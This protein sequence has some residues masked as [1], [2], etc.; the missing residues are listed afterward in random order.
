MAQENNKSKDNNKFTYPVRPI[1]TQPQLPSTPALPACLVS[2]AKVWY[3]WI[4]VLCF[5]A[6]ISSRSP[7]H[8][9]TIGE[10]DKVGVSKYIIYSNQFK[11]DFFKESADVILSDPPIVEGKKLDINSK[12]LMIFLEIWFNS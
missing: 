7:V 9:L 12:S 6:L 1:P 3:G 4:R 11:L 5:V 10:G 8:T 2:I